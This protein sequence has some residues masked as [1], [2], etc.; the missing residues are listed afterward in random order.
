VAE[1]QPSCPLRIRRGKKT[2]E[3]AFE[4]ASQLL[5][6]KAKIND[7]RK[8]KFETCNADFNKLQESLSNLALTGDEASQSKEY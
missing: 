8:L 3:L 4:R 2:G 6:L 7:F 5:E 1:I